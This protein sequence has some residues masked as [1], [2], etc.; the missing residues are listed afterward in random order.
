MS[1]RK[2][3]KILLPIVILLVSV[4]IFK[5]QVANKPGKVKPVVKEKTWLV[6]TLTV[7]RETL[8]PEIT[9][10][11]SVESP[12]LLNSASPGNAVVKATLV[13]SGDQVKKGQRLINLDSRD[14]STE[15]IE[16]QTQIDDL[17]HQ[18]KTLEVRY[19]SNQNILQT[20]RELLQF[21]EAE[22][23]RMTKLRTQNLGTD[24][25]L[26]T[27]KTNLGKQRLAV[28][29]RQFEVD[30]YP[31]KLEQ[32]KTSKVRLNARKR[33]A[34]LKIGR[35][36]VKAPFAGIIRDVAVSTGDR[37]NN[38]QTLLTMIPLGSL[39]IRAHIPARYQTIIQQSLA[40]GVLITA[41]KSGG[42]DSLDL[43]LTRLAG[44]AKPTGID[45]YFK[46]TNQATDAVTLTIGEL[47]TLNVEMPAIPGVF[48]LPF[49]ALYGNS[50]IYRL[51]DDRLEGMTIET[52]G[53]KQDSNGNHHLLVRSEALNEGDIIVTTHLPNA[54]T[55]L[56]VKTKI[57]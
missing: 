11:G 4:G 57:Q 43:Q 56:K 22:V 47:V 9:L 25:I 24:S 14:F 23:R 6:D 21:A 37:V 28:H 36:I 12:D 10:Y 13:R 49:Q 45:A 5:Y 41:R 16:A 3:T 40:Q 8:N 38:G 20:E 17:A 33:D 42:P 51:T 27:A 19:K 39:E 7:S 15:L 26:N 30:N 55:G 44:Q 2:L 46:I 32:L 54:V 1:A 18:I 29:A 34:Q 35:S 50:R 53:Q 48:Q 52:L 31:L